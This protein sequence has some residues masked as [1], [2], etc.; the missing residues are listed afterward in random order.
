VVRLGRNERNGDT[1]EKRNEEVIEQR[2]AGAAGRDHVL[3][4]E[5]PAGGVSVHDEDE[6][7][8]AGLAQDR[9]GRI[10]FVVYTRNIRP[11]LV[12][13]TWMKECSR[14]A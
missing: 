2:Q 12:A 3:E 13:G 11:P 4:A 10:R 6:G 14:R 7:R 8:E 1:P 9:A 5:G